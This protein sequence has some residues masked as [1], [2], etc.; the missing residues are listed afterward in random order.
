ME[1][2]SA[3]CHAVEEVARLVCMNRTIAHEAQQDILCLDQ[4]FMLVFKEG[5]LNRKF[6]SVR[7]NQKKIENPFN[8]RGIITKMNFMV[9]SE[10]SHSV[11]L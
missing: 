7:N 8:G 9:L 5:F 11:I 2:F 3:V 1:H 10:P 4:F 6:Q